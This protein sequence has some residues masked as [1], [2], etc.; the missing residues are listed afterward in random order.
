MDASTLIPAQADLPALKSAADRCTACELHGPATQT[1]FGSGNPTAKVLLVGEQPGDVEDQ[2]GVP[3]VGPA[4]K[5]LQRAVGEAGFGQGAVYVTNAVKH[6]RFE[7]R[8]KRRIHQTPQPEHI[9]ACNPWVAAEIAAVK[10]QIVVCLGATAVKALLGSK[11]RVTKD[12]GSLMPYAG[13]GAEPSMQ[14]LITIHPSAILRMPDDARDQGYADLVADLA[15]VAK[16][17]A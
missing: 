6:F 16:A 11:Y 15:V 5:L 14:A 3:F 10:P 7:L 12:R 2:R 13:P 8:G 9:H 1:V 17:V 4:G